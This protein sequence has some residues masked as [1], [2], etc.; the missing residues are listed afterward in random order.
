MSHQH[1]LIL[2]L[3]LL[4]CRAEFSDR[5][6]T[7]EESC[8]GEDKIHCGD[9]SCV[10]THQY[11]DGKVDCPDGSDEN[12]CPDHTP[13][14]D[15]CKPESH[16]LCADHS[17]CIPNL[18]I[19]NN[20]TDCID[21]SDEVNC[22]T[23]PPP[24]PN[25][26]CKGFTCKNDSR[27]I[28]RLWLCDG[29][30]DCAD[31]SDENAEA[32]RHWQPTGYIG[33]HE[34]VTDHGKMF[35]TKK[36]YVCLDKTYCLA[37]RHMCNGIKDC[38]DGSDE[39]P[40][41]DSWASMCANRTCGKKAT[42]YPERDGP[43]CVC[44]ETYFLFNET[45]HACQPRNVCAEARPQCTHKC[46]DK[47]GSFICS[48][49]DGYLLDTL[50]I[51]FMCIAP[52]PEAML[53]FSTQNEIK[54][55]KIRTRK[56]VTVA[57]GIKQ[58]HGVSF[59]GKN[60]YWVETA[61]GHQAIVK[62]PLENIA[63]TKTV[64]VGLGLEDPGDI[65]IDW[66]GRNFYFSD[67][68][69][70]TIS[71]CKLD[72]Q[73]C[74]TLKTAAKIPKHLTLDVR[75]RKMY[76]ADIHNVHS[77][78]VIMQSYMDGSDPIALVVDLH[79]FPN[80]LIVDASG[81]RLYFSDGTVKGA[82]LDT[83]EVFVVN[84]HGIHYHEPYAL[85][86]F[87]HVIYWSDW[88]TDTIQSWDKLNTHSLGAV[89]S[90]DTPVYGLYMYHPILYRGAPEPG[91][92]S[93]HHIRLLGPN[94]PIAACPEGM[95]LDDRERCQQ[96]ESYHP[97]YIVVGVDSTFTLV[98]YDAL[99]GHDDEPV[100]FDMGHVQAMAYDTRRDELYIF[101]SKWKAI[102]HI[103]M[104]EFHTGKPAVL[105]FI[106][107]HDVVDMDY[108]YVAD[109]LY[110]ADAGR[111]FLEVVSIKTMK[112]S[113]IH[114]FEQETPISICV[115]PDYGKILVAVS[116]IEDNENIHIDI[117]NLDGTGRQ[118]ILMNNL[119]GPNI[120]MKYSQ[121]MDN[122]FIADEGN[123]IIDFMH[124]LGTARETY[125][126]L[127]TSVT[128]LEVTDSL[129]LW[130]T[131][132]NH[133]LYWSDIHEANRHIR[134]VEMSM[135]PNTTYLHI[136]ATWQPPNVSHPCLQDPMPC[137]DVCVQI[138]MN[139]TNIGEA[140]WQPP[141]VSHPCLQD[142]MP[143]SDVCVQIPMNTTNIGED[144]NA[145]NE[146]PP[147]TGDMAAPQRVP[148]VSAGPHAA[149]WQPPNVSH[150]CLQDPMPCSD[151]CVQIPMNTTNIVNV[152]SG[153]SKSG[154]KC[155]CPAGMVSVDGNCTEKVICED[156]DEIVCHH[157]N[158]CV[159]RTKA[160]DGKKDC[161]YGEDEE[162]CV[163]STKLPPKCPADEKLC[164]DMCILKS[165]PCVL[166]TTPEPGVTTPSTEPCNLT[167]EFACP[168]GYCI[169]RS[170]LCNGR[171][172][173]TDGADEVMHMCDTLTC[174]DH[175]FMNDCTDGADEVM[176][177]CD[178][179]TC[180]DHEFMCTAGYCILKKFVCDGDPDCRDESD[181]L[182]CNNHTCAA[183]EF[184]CHDDQ[185][186]I[187]MTR[188]CDAQMDCPDGSDEEFCLPPE[189]PTQYVTP[190]G[191]EPEPE[192][193]EDWEYTCELNRSICLPLTS[194]CNHKPDCPGATDEVDCLRPCPWEG[195]LR[196]R[197][198][199]YK[200][201]TAPRICDGMWD[202]VD[203]EDET[204][205][206]CNRVNKTSKL[207]P[208]RIYLPP[209]EC[210]DGFNCS[211]GQ[212]VE[213]MS[214]CDN[215]YDCADGSDEG[216]Q[217]HTA[218]LNNNCSYTCKPTPTGH[219]CRCPNGFD[220]TE[221]GSCN[222]RDECALEY[223]S[224]HCFNTPGSFICSC[225]KGY[226]L[227]LDH[228]SCKA[229]QGNMS[230]LFM[231]GNSIK[232]FTMGG[233]VSTEYIEN[234]TR[235]TSMDY[236]I[237]RNRLYLSAPEEGQLKVID[238]AHI[239]NISNVGKPTKVA[240]DWVTGSVYFADLRSTNPRIRVCHAQKM[241]C[242][243]L[244]KLPL[245]SDVTALAIDPASRR[246]FYA[247]SRDLESVIWSSTTAG[248]HVTQ[249]TVVGNCSGLAVDSFKKRL[250]IAE[251]GPARIIAVD[252]S[253]HML[254]D[255]LTED[256]H[257]QSP[258]DLAIFEDHIYY[259]DGK[260]SKLHRCVLFGKKQ[261]E[262]YLQRL[263][264][265]KS[266]MIRHPSVQR[267]DLPDFCEET[268]CNNVCV[269]GDL[270]GI[271][272]CNDGAVAKDGYCPVPSS[273]QLPIFNG[274]P[275]R[276]Y[277]R[278]SVPP[279]VIITITAF[280]TVW[281]VGLLYYRFVYKGAPL[282]RRRQPDMDYAQVTFQNSMA[283]G[284]SGPSSPAVEPS[285]HMPAIDARPSEFVNPLEFFRNFNWRQF[286][287][288]TRPIVSITIF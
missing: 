105:L 1:L 151:V 262:I 4:S 134:R 41:C 34:C 101:D 126:A 248:R 83:G 59:D 155:L 6:Q 184:A 191:L 76:W 2:L 187:E 47:N 179:L 219:H 5:L 243:V 244:Q 163:N 239:L 240:V 9:G 228:R 279:A 237:V 46:T 136:Q 80:G 121:K 12:L 61:I 195:S 65:S 87:E 215:H 236:D 154:Y 56:T 95:E 63:E 281:I 143:C 81:G 54:Y 129:V 55:V 241:R 131:R 30:Y 263:F 171:N 189:D 89:A 247:V 148:P 127:S 106:G 260:T 194:R 238:G 269:L 204:P 235:I 26:P 185:L 102:Y 62:A 21:G 100:H 82:R 72:S 188:R 250:F 206:I 186:C 209:R 288:N 64:L 223:C 108:D 113:I 177:M 45:T 165:T 11:C 75:N 20:E 181:E 202:C 261:C 117:F 137:S 85:T 120:R 207:Y 51:S 49:D 73:M 145:S 157:S 242:A 183:G 91:A 19:C 71:V 282:F 141:N 266:F 217:C 94:G 99:G 7:Y 124:P 280:V 208:K 66:M 167:M 205:E 25:A 74:M 122:V 116:E 249:V 224:Q 227:R 201:V 285:V 77:G 212:C 218:C 231:S 256:R 93:P 175:E 158:Q 31:G 69:H 162:N 192:N 40:F 178:T 268:Q 257:L 125:R 264:D 225:H 144:N 220:V 251:A 203:G 70:G 214:V 86:V 115:V 173:C 13:E 103:K 98:R 10:W 200:C 265:L 114:I 79:N 43:E 22:T 255:V 193:C 146:V 48:C 274:K 29:A 232:S 273:K 270:E 37:Y 84:Q 44:E 286:R 159:P 287:R 119:K 139:T 169:E 123:H 39:G 252:Y 170:L 176:H 18:W 276:E 58:A 90:L 196:C 150:P 258:H 3:C 230:I 109:N 97:G 138:P 32:C 14:P 164:D 190:F 96:K 68:E 229:L 107:L 142:P 199:P 33:H 28:S 245:H 42:C 118:H 140:T 104:S 271:C 216:G 50:K 254:K 147:H 166:P 213:W 211:N 17:K 278:N 112:R 161:K 38:K 275:V 132:R 210:H 27:C 197:L 36:H 60:V 160:C 259:L 272:V 35:M 149:T 92:I 226:A 8:L 15:T 67:S 198:E 152:T 180:L 78:P 234:A 24:A 222:D 130:T 246:L 110:F 168:E 267:D 153:S 53:F 283:E 135:F 111:K 128:Q 57:T 52:E 277:Q 284:S 233:Q 156:R 182:Y 23:L 133:R 88:A 221:D 253:G 172:D 174:L 16:F